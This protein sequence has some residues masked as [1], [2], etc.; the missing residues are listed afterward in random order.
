V[1]IYQNLAFR[2]VGFSIILLTVFV[3]IVLF[4]IFYK[5]AKDQSIMQRIQP[6][7]RKIQEE[8]KT[9]KEEQAKQ[10]MDL[11]KE[12]K[13]NPFSNFLLILIQLPIFIA[14]FQ[15]FRNELSTS[16]FDN[17]LFLSLINLGENS[18]V[19]ALI[20]AGLQYFQ[21]KLMLPPQQAAGEE[22]QM[23]RIGKTMV[24]VGPVITFF[25]LTNLPSALGV[26]WATSSLFSVGQQIYIN[27]K[28]P[29]EL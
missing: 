29:K 11:Y 4:P 13:V 21:S 16:L 26:Y 18:V 28:I 24:V 14:L 9:N 25:I 23:A 7:L 6:K 3:R 20:A 27:K 17:K 19:I 10:M 15:I 8:H 22:N 2:D 12:N 1:F 5:S